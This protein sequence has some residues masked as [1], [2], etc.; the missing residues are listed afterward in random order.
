MA[1]WLR[2]LRVLRVVHPAVLRVAHR[3]E[4]L[5]VVAAAAVVG[6]VEVEH[7]LLL[8]FP[9]ARLCADQTESRT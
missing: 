8:Q 9:L 2:L 3:V 1:S 6:D 7:L 4:P 5:A